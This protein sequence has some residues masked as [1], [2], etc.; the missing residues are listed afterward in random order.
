M[1]K[2]LD[3]RHY[4]DVLPGFSLSMVEVFS[5]N[6]LQLDNNILLNL[7]PK[8]VVVVSLGITVSPLSDRGL[9]V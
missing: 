2:D 8:M 6:Q 3:I 4:R 7:M 1:L 9:I 5:S